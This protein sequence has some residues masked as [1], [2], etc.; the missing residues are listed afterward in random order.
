MNELDWQKMDGLIPAI[1]QNAENGEVLMLGYMNEEALKITLETKTVCFYSR[2]KQRLWIKGESSGYKL[3]LQS[4][5]FDCDGDSLLIQALPAGPT[6]HLGFSSCFQPRA[7]FQLGFLDKL[8]KLIAVRSQEN[9]STS[10]TATLLASGLN[11]CAQKL[12]EEAV[13]TVISAVSKNREELINEASDLVFHL[14]VL[15]QACELSFYELI[16]CLQRR[17]KK[18]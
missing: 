5:S 7:Q 1:I 18:S 2:S 8:I 17:H 9:Q 10:Y 14:L 16:A 6:C 15:L 13:E 4:I 3:E 11:R 12:G